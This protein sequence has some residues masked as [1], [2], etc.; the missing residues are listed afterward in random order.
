MSSQRKPVFLAAVAALAVTAGLALS[1]SALRA[2]AADAPKEDPEVK[3]GRE[4]HEELLKSGVKIIRDPKIVQRV[5][6]IGEKIA[7]V[8]NETPLEAKWG[9]SKHVKY[10][11]KFFVIDDKDVNA[12]SLPGGFIYVNKG[13]LDYVQSDDELAG[14]LGHEIIHAAHHHVAKLQREQS[15]LNGQMALGLLAAILARVPTEDTYNLMTGFQLLGV[16][17]LNGHGQNAE[18]DSDSGGVIIS[19][20]AGYNPVG[21]LTFMERLARDEKSRRDV[22]LG[23]FRTHPP[24]RERADAMIAQIRDFG[25]PI[26]RREVTDAIKASTRTAQAA[27]S[28]ATELV[29]DGKVVYRL[30]S[31]ERAKRAAETINRLLDQDLQIYDVKKD[32]TRVVARGQTLFAVQPEDAA[33]SPASAGSPESVA[34]QAYK[35]LRN[36]LYK[37]VL[38]TAY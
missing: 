38:D 21:A 4:T 17:K 14:V 9:S 8:A 3:M 22:D 11:Y 23:I 34:D 16:Q 35:V 27:G 25:L 7:A 30:A 10:D 29:L 19:R 18:R 15:R 37:Q 28:S 36:A 31:P 26:N 5:E 32:G 20:K 1:P 2:A 24:S 6:T 13:L 33:L 12:F